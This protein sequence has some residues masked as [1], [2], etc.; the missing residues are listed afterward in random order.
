MGSFYYHVYH[1]ISYFPFFFHNLQIGNDVSQ[2]VG[3]LL[4]NQLL[5]VSSSVFLI[6]YNVQI[7][8]SFSLFANS[9]FYNCMMLIERGFSFNIYF[10]FMIRLK[11]VLSSIVDFI[12]RKTKEWKSIVTF[13]LSWIALSWICQFYQ[14]M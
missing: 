11:L 9:K 2:F 5:Q 4:L 1:I 10:G 7:C 8:S 12:Q 3:P 14:I 6:R 13:S